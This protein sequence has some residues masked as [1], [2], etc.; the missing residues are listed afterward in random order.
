MHTNSLISVGHAYSSLQAYAC[1]CNAAQLSEL[2][3]V[4]KIL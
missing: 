3:S 1:S 4:V 2:Q